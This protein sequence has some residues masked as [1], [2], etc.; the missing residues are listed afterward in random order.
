[1]GLLPPS[2]NIMPKTLIL[3]LEYMII[4]FTLINEVRK[5]SKKNE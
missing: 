5:A 4:I 3:I 1:M 2:L